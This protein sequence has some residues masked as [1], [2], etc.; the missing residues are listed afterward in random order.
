MVKTVLYYIPVKKEYL[1]K[2]EY[3]EA[4]YQL[5]KNSG[6][7]VVVCDSFLSACLA[8]RKA[9]FMF[10]W[11]W[12]R[13]LPMILLFKLLG[14]KVVTTGAIHMYDLSG[15]G[16]FYDKGFFYRAFNKIGIYLSDI[17]V[18]ISKNQK[19]SIESC[20]RGAAGSV[21]YPSLSNRY[22]FDASLYPERGKSILVLAWLTRV[23]CLR[24]G[25]FD[26]VNAY[27]SLLKSNPQLIGGRQL[28]LAGK[29]GDALPILRSMISK[30]G[31]EDRVSFELDISQDRKLELYMSSHCLFAPSYMEGFGNANLEAMACGLPVI[32]T[33][34][35]ASKES[36]GDCGIVVSDVG[37]DAAIKGLQLFLEFNQVDV[38]AMRKSARERV[39]KYFSEEVRVQKLN[40]ILVTRGI[41]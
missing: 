36:V 38:E 41:V 13:S 28:I 3:Y 10:A 32:C 9:D 23:S 25:V 31:I 39:K 14:K 30:L 8:A 16:S 18:Y 20:V 22:F 4:D 26:A 12:G 35:G 1:D 17:N 5:L 15:S 37:V 29:S 2:W 24:K 6:F 40:E 34:E 19:L 7:F 21:L 11:W 33:S 27:A